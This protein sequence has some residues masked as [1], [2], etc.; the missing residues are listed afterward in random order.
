MLLTYEEFFED[1]WDYVSSK[2]IDDHYYFPREQM[3]RSITK[4]VYD[5]YSADDG[6]LHPKYYA[7]IVESM[8]FHLI[9]WEAENTDHIDYN[10]S[11]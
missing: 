9:K 4:D 1:M 5:I 6:R 7:R 8:F 11:Y 3:M 10:K 2:I